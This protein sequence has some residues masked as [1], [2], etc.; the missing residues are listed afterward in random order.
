MRDNYA[1]WALYGDYIDHSGPFNKN[2]FYRLLYYS[3]GRKEPKAEN[4]E[5][6]DR[7]SVIMMWTL[8]EW[9]GDEMQD[10]VII[11]TVRPRPCK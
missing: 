5:V 10:A 1:W 9:L 4:T 7:D 8:I 2:E 3:M 6:Y 11:V